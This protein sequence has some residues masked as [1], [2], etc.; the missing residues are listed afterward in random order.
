[1]LLIF[2][3]VF[4]LFL[5]IEERKGKPK[6]EREKKMSISHDASI[7]VLFE[8]TWMNLRALE[9]MHFPNVFEN[10]LCLILAWACKR[11][12]QFQIYRA[13][14]RVNKCAKCVY[15]LSGHRTF[16]MDIDNFGCTFF[17]IHIA[18]IHPHTCVF[19]VHLV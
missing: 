8:W 5:L 1:M 19:W 2:Q 17:T 9:L 11:I 18:Y 14:Q 13:F 16:R 15:G 4:F 10:N 6:R 3:L 12:A 7:F